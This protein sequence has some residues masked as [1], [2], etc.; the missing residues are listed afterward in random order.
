MNVFGR[1]AI[2]VKMYLDTCII[3]KLYL[4]EP[5]SEAI[6]SLVTGVTD[7]TSSNLAVTELGSVLSRKNREGQ[8]QSSVRDQIWDLFKGHIEENYWSFISVSDELCRYSD[9]IIK[10]CQDV[11]SIRTLDAIHLA[12]C[13]QYKIFPLLTTD[14]NMLKAAQFL[15][16][17]LRSIPT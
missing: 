15:E 14:K 11:V 6:Q 3:A 12:T 17:P 13:L 2:V 4:P 10:K 16:I 5:E 7:L 1:I 9:E 8:I